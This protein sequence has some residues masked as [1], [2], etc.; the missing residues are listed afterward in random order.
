MMEKTQTMDKVEGIAQSS[1]FD[2]FATP[3]YIV[4]QKFSPSTYYLLS[5]KPS[6]LLYI[7]IPNFDSFFTLKIPHPNTFVTKHLDA[8]HRIEHFTF[9]T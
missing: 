7:I 5:F 8:T 9:A 2:D 1:Y 6:I 3:S 4:L